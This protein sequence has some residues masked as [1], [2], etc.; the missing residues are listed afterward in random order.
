MLA[1]CGASSPD[2][3]G[4]AISRCV[5]RGGTKHGC[6][7]AVNYAKAHGDSP[8]KLVREMAADNAANDPVAVAAGVLCS[9][10]R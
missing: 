7:C 10:V 8:A 4:A 3:T 6:E 2:Q 1:G 9:G 5:Q